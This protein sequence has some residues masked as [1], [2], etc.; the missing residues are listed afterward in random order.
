MKNRPLFSI[1]YSLLLVLCSLFFVLCLS[2]ASTTGASSGAASSGGTFDDEDN[3]L[4]NGDFEEG[5][6]EWGLPGLYLYVWEN[7]SGENTPWATGTQVSFVHDDKRNGTV[8]KIDGAREGVEKQTVAR[9]D[10]FPVWGDETYKI[11]GFMRVDA[12]HTGNSVP[13]VY[14]QYHSGVV[15]GVKPGV[16]RSRVPHVDEYTKGEWYRFEFNFTVDSTETFT[17]NLC[18]IAY[19]ARI[20]GA[21]VDKGG[22]G[23]AAYFDDLAMFALE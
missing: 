10:V 22:E 18:N 7:S 19:D 20:D 9:W 11:T 3:L 4:Y 16:T 21:R 2:C 17:V 8:L 6:N 1:P 14:T 23:G 12:D 15:F 5:S 13:Q